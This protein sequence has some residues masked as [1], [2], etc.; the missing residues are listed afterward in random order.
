M[1]SMSEPKLFSTMCLLFTYI[2]V[3]IT[4]YRRGIMLNC[5]SGVGDSCREVVRFE[6]NAYGPCLRGRDLVSSAD[7][8]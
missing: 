4:S 6:G 3:N 1:R 5:N 2:C 7:G 8:V